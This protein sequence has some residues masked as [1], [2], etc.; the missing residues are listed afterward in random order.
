C[1]PCRVP[2]AQLLDPLSR[3]A[4]DL[5]LPTK[6]LRVLE[7][8]DC[9]NV[10]KALEEASGMIEGGCR[11]VLVLVAERIESEDKR[12]KKFALF[13]DVCFSMVVSH[14]VA[15]CDY[16]VLGTNIVEDPAPP[17]SNDGILGRTLD[18]RT[19]GDLLDSLAI[20]A[21]D[22]DQCFYINLYSPI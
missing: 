2:A 11:N 22:I 13:S 3:M 10:I 1:G 6:N 18:A 12:L 8:F 4:V 7:T 21:E 5:N 19:I 15:S 16:E 14:D 9:V 20:D 17:A